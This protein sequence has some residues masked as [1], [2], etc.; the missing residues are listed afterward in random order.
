M[1]GSSYIV[2]ISVYHSLT[3]FLEG[4][5]LFQEAIKLTVINETLSVDVDLVELAVDLLLAD[6]LTTKLCLGVLELH[7]V[8][9]GNL[10]RPVRLLGFLQ[11]LQILVSLLSS[12][13]GFPLSLLFLFLL[14]F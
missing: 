10:T 11:H 9:D 8:S 7:K 3:Y 13:F 5:G 1:N 6:Y 4:L 12:L 2:V 14:F